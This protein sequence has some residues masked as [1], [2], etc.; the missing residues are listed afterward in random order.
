MRTL[1]IEAKSN[2]KINIPDNYINELPDKIGLLTTVQF[3]DELEHLKKQL[4][5]KKKLVFYGKGSRCKYRG[6][7]LGC[8]AGAAEHVKEMVQAFLYIG[9]GEFHPIIIALKTEKPV[10]KFNP[11]TNEFSKVKKEEIE[12]IA[13]KLKGLKLKFLSS[14][15]IGIL[16]SAKQGQANMA[17]AK[18]I[19]SQFKEKSFH[20]FLFDTLDFD[21]LMNFPQIECWINTACNRIVYD[22]AIERGISILNYEDI[23]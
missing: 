6:Q 3:I 21:Q 4:E 1:F 17:A 2:A 15:N 13:K 20:T 12:K 9:S 18:K 10:F 8:D 19:K 11:T 16:A 5:S 7:I 23:Q 14:N 22:D